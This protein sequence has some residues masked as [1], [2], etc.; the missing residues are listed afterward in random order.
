MDLLYSYIPKWVQSTK[1]LRSYDVMKTCWTWKLRYFAKKIGEKSKKS[2]G[3][4]KSSEY[5]NFTRF[6]LIQKE[7]GNSNMFCKFQ[8]HSMQIFFKMSNFK[9]LKIE[10]G[11]VHP[12][13]W[14]WR[15]TLPRGRW[16]PHFFHENDRKGCKRDYLYALG[17]FL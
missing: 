6:L 2:K 11:C 1:A 10:K 5:Q 9:C 8:H 12:T 16:Y 17:N 7:S 15:L 14:L 13:L 4:Y 3:C